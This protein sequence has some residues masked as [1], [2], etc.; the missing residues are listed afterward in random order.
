MSP[1]H[2]IVPTPEQ[3]SDTPREIPTVVQLLV[4]RWSQTDY[5]RGM[6]TRKRPGTTKIDRSSLE[7]WLVKSGKVIEEYENSKAPAPRH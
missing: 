6:A 1:S 2:T 7:E 4:D 3:L 5:T